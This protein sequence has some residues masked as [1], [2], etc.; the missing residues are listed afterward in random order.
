[1]DATAPSELGEFLR[2]RRARL[3]P[4]D[5]GVTA[6]GGRRQVETEGQ[7]GGGGRAVDQDRPDDALTR[8]LVA[9]SQGPLEFHNTSVPLLPGGLQVRVTLPATAACAL[10]IQSVAAR[11]LRI[12]GVVTTF[13][14]GTLTMAAIQLAACSHQE[15]Y[16]AVVPLMKR[17]TNCSSVTSGSM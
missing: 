8:R 2:T 1:M 3:L 13:I 10:G 17:S 14:T 9:R 16:P 15:P 11:R 12:S 5:V 4:R 7:V 6:Y